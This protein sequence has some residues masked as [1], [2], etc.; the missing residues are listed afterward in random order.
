MNLYPTDRPLIGSR[1]ILLNEVDST[2]EYLKREIKSN[3][4]LSDGTLVTAEFQTDGKGQMGNKWLSASEQNILFS[5][6]LKPKNFPINKSWAISAASSLGIIDFLQK[7]NIPARVKWPNDIVIE[8]N[9]IA[10]ILIE[11]SLQSSFISSAIVG[12][13][14]NF[15]QMD[16]PDFNRKAISLINFINPLPPKLEVLKE[17]CARIEF[18]IFKIKNHQFDFI[19]S[20][21]E[22]NLYLINQKRPFLINNN[23]VEAE[24]KGISDEGLLKLLIHNE[25]QFFD[26]KEISY[27]V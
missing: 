15:A 1:I 14:F 6:Y 5:F 20:E 19:K 13:G 27:A 25:I 8:S 26:L 9:K 16:F 23:L 24:I 17:I 2:N 10:G 3:P 22:K 21:F 4:D 11:N 7:K 12:I 18:Y